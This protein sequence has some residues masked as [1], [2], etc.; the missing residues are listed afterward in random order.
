MSKGRFDWIRFDKQ[1]E[2]E[3]NALREEFKRYEQMVY[4]GKEK[5]LRSM[6]LP[7]GEYLPAAQNIMQ[8]MYFYGDTTRLPSPLVILELMYYMRGK[9]IRRECQERT[10]QFVEE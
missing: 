2:E 1:A 7:E 3:Q 8:M 4:E 10:R 6:P 5:E 9:K